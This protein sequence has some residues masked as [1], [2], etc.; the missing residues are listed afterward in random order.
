M[1]LIF[2][3]VLRVNARL[4]CAPI[5]TIRLLNPLQRLVLRGRQF[6]LH[7]RLAFCDGYHSHTP[8]ASSCAFR[9]SHLRRPALGEN[10]KLENPMR[11]SPAHFESLANVRLRKPQGLSLRQHASY[12]DDVQHERNANQLPRSSH[13]NPLLLDGPA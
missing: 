8:T 2:I 11:G 3:S 1:S 7:N 12:G 4:C 13:P 6:L 9:I 10:C 5:C